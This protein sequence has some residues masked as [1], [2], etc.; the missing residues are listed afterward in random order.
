VY[1]NILVATDGS[2][3]ANLGLRE[4]I[5]LARRLGGRMRLVHV[6]NKTP[7]ISPGATPSAIDDLVTQLRS[8]GESIL[9]EAKSAARAAG[10]EV[11]SRLIE[12]VGERAGE[13][14]VAE[15]SDWPAQLIVCG[16]HGRRGVR[17]LLMGSDA[18]YVVRHAPVPVLL[19]RGRS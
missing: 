11:D 7:W 9:H 12:A 6:V 19:V 14:V 5:D 17:R 18:E 15:A 10:V 16:T 4:A 8:T 3:P 1:Q 13:I 2:E